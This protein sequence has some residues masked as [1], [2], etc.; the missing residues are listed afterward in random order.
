MLVEVVE[1]DGGTRGDGVF[2]V[3]ERLIVRD[4]R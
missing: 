4:A 2:S 3:V 1:G